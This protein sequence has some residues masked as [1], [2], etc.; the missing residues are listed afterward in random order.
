[1]NRS[2]FLK[3]ACAAATSVLFSNCAGTRPATP[4]QP[5]AWPPVSYKT[6]RAFAYDCDAEHGVSFWKR[7]GRMHK[8]VLNAP[9]VVLSPSQVQ[10]LLGDVTVAKPLDDRKPCYVPHHA[11]VFYDA[12]DQPVATL[13]ICFTCRRFDATPRG[14]P[15]QI[16]YDIPWTIL[17][18]LNVPAERDKRFYGQLYKK[19]HGK[20]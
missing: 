6:V 18:E 11:F 8:G 12:A 20:S 17:K 16:G 10:R 4:G 2:V 3:T 14:L 19:L 15:E 1:M 13:E 7:H 9:G 5:V